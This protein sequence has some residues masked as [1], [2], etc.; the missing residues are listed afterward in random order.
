M[1]M[2]GRASTEAATTR[3]SSRLS[4]PSTRRPCRE[5]TR[6]PWTAS[7]LRDFALVTVRG[8]IHTREDLLD[9]VRGKTA[10]YGRQ[11]DS[12]R[13][14]RVWGDTAVVAALLWT[15]GTQGGEP[16]YRL[17]FSDFYLRRPEGLRYVFAQS[18]LRLPAN[19]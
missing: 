10:V 4:I 2:V 1:V 7:W 14:V 11:E 18:S 13:T 12:Q 3:R 16:F 15:K 5:T 9:E 17:W 6:P 19:P 8:T